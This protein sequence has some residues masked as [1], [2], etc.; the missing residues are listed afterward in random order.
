[1]ACGRI[2]GGAAAIVQAHSFGIPE[3]PHKKPWS[4]AYH[5][6]AVRVYAQSLPRR[7]QHDIGVLFSSSADIL[8][9]QSIPATLAEDWVIATKYLRAASAAIAKLHATDKIDCKEPWEAPRIEGVPP[10]VIRFD[11]LARLTTS[12]GAER[13]KQAALTVQQHVRGPQPDVLGAFERRL[14]ARVA[15]GAQIVELA[16]E[17]GYSERSTYRVLAN[18]WK[19]LDVPGRSEGLERAA[20][21]GLI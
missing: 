18:L 16:A 1:M 15:G 9:E 4:G 7:Y 6:R 11:A 5:R 21:E 13:L 20:S 19:K 12:K 17:L 3:G 10:M 8:D 14:L 2:V